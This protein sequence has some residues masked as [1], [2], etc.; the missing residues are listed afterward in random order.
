MVHAQKWLKKLPKP[1]KYS[2]SLLYRVNNKYLETPPLCISL[3]HKKTKPKQIAYIPFSVKDTT[4]P[5]PPSNLRVTSE[6]IYNII[7]TWDAAFDPESGISGYVF[8][9]GSTPG[10]ADI[11]WWQSTSANTITG[12]YTQDMD[13]NEGDT[14]YVSVYATNNANINSSVVSSNA[15]AIKWD[16]LGTSSNNITYS[17][18]GGWR[19]SE[20]DTIR[21][22]LIK[23]FQ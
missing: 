22:F 16:E 2:E 23:W 8:G 21:L 1:N 4:A 18:S 20:K 7:A 15:I 11:R 3:V 9:V 6:S 13:L 12:L 10:E 17:F 14:V 19:Q 5:L